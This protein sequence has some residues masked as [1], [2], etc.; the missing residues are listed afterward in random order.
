MRDC[1]LAK[2]IPIIHLSLAS[3]FQW[4]RLIH[5]CYF[6]DI[7]LY[8]SLLYW[9]YWGQYTSWGVFR[10]TKCL[11]TNISWMEFLSIDFIRSSIIAPCVIYS[12]LLGAVKHLATG[13]DQC[14]GKAVS[15]VHQ[16]QINT[17]F[18]E[19][20]FPWFCLFFISKWSLTLFEGYSIIFIREL[21]SKCVKLLKDS[22]AFKAE[23]SKY[24]SKFS[25]LHCLIFIMLI[26]FFNYSM[27]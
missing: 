16:N 2:L 13:T 18:W 17:V 24:L 7:Q 5:H 12:H 21:Q 20:M 4:K 10:F 14:H 26:Y 3:I 1:L 15:K 11:R 27:L 19:R 25:L 23:Y 9:F 8:L 6:D 22:Y